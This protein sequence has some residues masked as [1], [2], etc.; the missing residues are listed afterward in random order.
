MGI[1]CIYDIIFVRLLQ[2]I[3]G[4]YFCYVV[5][6]IFYCIKGNMELVGCD[7]IIYDCVNDIINLYLCNLIIIFFIVYV[8][9]L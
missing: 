5:E 9:E 2:F 1:F 7:E 8:F 6:I 3:Y 4:V